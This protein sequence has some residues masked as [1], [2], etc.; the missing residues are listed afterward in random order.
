[1]K[2]TER[3]NGGKRWLLQY[4]FLFI[5][6]MINKRKQACQ[7]ILAHMQSKTIQ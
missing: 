3:T 7:C 5:S 1:M 6:Y 2:L 4:Y